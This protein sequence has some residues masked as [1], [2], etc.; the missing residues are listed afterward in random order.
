MIGSSS[1]PSGLIEAAHEIHAE[2]GGER[3]AR[4]VDHIDDAFEPHLRQIGHDIGR[5]AKS[6]EWEGEAL[7]R[8]LGQFQFY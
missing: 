6:G 4:A 8:C 5:N 7:R 2:A 1:R 3:R